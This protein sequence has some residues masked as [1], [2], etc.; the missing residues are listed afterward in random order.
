MG[1]SAEDDTKL[2]EMAAAGLS[3]SQI[4]VELGKGSRN[5]VIGRAKRQGIPLGGRQGRRR[6]AASTLAGRM[7]TGKTRVARASKP[8]GQ[9][10]VKMGPARFEFRQVAEVRDVRD[11]FNPAKM[12]AARLLPIE[13][14]R[15]G[16][17]K[18]PLYQ[19]DER[20]VFCGLGTAHEDGRWRP[21]C[22]I[23]SEL[24]RLSP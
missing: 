18:W 11:A 24:S 16:C 20:R 21:Y 1:W 2:R 9:R 19:G 14:L 22:P 15:D 12:T 23:H 8:V 6:G 4:A 5:A 17:C 3:A 10:A 13:G 7:V